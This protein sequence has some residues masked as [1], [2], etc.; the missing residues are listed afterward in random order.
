MKKV[1]K[2][3]SGSYICMTT[4]TKEQN[5]FV[6]SNGY[7][8]SHILQD[9]IDIMRGEPNPLYFALIQGL[10]TKLEKDGR[11]KCST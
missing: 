8:P 6:R 11:V 3:S 2:K 4:I 5:D 7:K 1:G 9:A 10:V